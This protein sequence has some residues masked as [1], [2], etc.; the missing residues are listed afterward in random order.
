M[1]F[2]R[3]IGASHGVS[4]RS[5]FAA[6]EGTRIALYRDI[7]SNAF[8]FYGIVA[9]SNGHAG[10]AAC[11]QATAGRAAGRNDSGRIFI[12][13]LEAISIASWFEYARVLVR[14]V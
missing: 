13:T 11:R 8:R 3:R 5:H 14:Y 4:S 2:H 10:R 6:N 7:A 9:N 12:G 1:G